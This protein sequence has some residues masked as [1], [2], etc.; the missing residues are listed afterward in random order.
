M[1]KIL[2]AC[3]F[4]LIDTS[5]AFAKIG[6]PKPITINNVTY[7]SHANYVEAL[8]ATTQGQIWR[9][10]FPGSIK[11]DSINPNL[12]E[13]VQWHIVCCLKVTDDFVEAKFRQITYR[14]NRV[15][16]KIVS[17]IPAE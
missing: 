1:K 6:D 7:Q 14:L 17:A 11:P 12:E 3:F 9:T 16:G 13:D 10:T 2:F 8:N 15:T 5:L 4:I